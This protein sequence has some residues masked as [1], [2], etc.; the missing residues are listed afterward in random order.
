MLGA[1]R[2][3][4]H[5]KAC[6]IGEMCRRLPS[7]ASDTSPV[8]GGA[9]GSS[10]STTSVD[11]CLMSCARPTPRKP[12]KVLIA[13]ADYTQR[14]V[15]ARSLA[16]DG[17]DAFLHGVDC[18]NERPNSHEGNAT[19]ASLDA[20]VDVSSDMPVTRT[21]AR[22]AWPQPERA[23]SRGKQK[24]PEGSAGRV[25]VVQLESVEGDYWG[26]RSPRQSRSA[27]PRAP[28]RDPFKSSVRGPGLWR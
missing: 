28:G 27:V 8:A 15:A 19:V 18:L 25:V 13:Q 5:G 2:D 10:T 6:A 1:H 21:P 17:S 14:R 16:P 26:A 7:R 4:V 11:S 12:S 22:S 3:R 24:R 23:A 20:V 9:P